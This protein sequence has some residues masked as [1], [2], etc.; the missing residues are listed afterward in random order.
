MDGRSPWARTMR[1]ALTRMFGDDATGDLVV[2][3]LTASLAP[4][5]YRKYN[6]DLEQ[7]REFCA[8]EAVLPLDVTVVQVVRYLA[9]QCSLGTSNADTLRGHCKAINRFLRDH[10]REPCA[11][12]PVVTDFL[13]AVQ[14][15]QVPLHAQD[16]RMYMPADVMLDVHDFAESLVERLQQ[17]FAGDGVRLLRDCLASVLAFLAFHRA[18]TTIT[19]TAKQVRVQGGSLHLALHHEK[20]RLGPHARTVV[21]HEHPRLAAMIDAYRGFRAAL[22]N[23]ST[24]VPPPT[25][26][27]LPGE[28]PA[29]WSSEQPTAW[30]S[31]ACAA[32]SAAPPQ[33]WVWT[34]HSLR[35]G[36][37]TAANAQGVPEST[38]EHYGSWV[39][40]STTLRRVYI[41]PGVPPSRGSEF[42]FRW[43]EAGRVRPAVA[44]PGR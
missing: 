10:G 22:Y 11:L 3:L 31:H 34:S 37:A 29:L 25:L 9:W 26:W 16:S 12:G 18:G 23:C 14:R 41:H 7:F 39:P 2:S 13:R 44:A 42:F 19:L 15:H 21:I 33:G 38:I 28:R 36:A 32:V 24:E 5:S 40:G 30:L 27:A 6:Y 43:A 1:P 8:E 4:G 35:S 20:G 17:C